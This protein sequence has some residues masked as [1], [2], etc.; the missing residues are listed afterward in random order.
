MIV[1]LSQPAA[2]FMEEQCTGNSH[3]V[4]LVSQ[5]ILEHPWFDVVIRGYR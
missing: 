1:S 2:S 3:C 4:T 5:K